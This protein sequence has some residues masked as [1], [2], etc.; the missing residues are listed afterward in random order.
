MNRFLLVT[1]RKSDRLW[2]LLFCFSLLAFCLRALIPN[3][4]MPTQS[5][6]SETSPLSL[7]FCLPAG[8]QSVA[9][10]QFLQSLQDDTS[11]STEQTGSIHTCPF[12]LASVDAILAVPI[13]LSDLRLPDVRF[14][15]PESQAP[16]VDTLHAGP[17]LGPRAPPLV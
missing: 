7:S 6:Q 5:T 15:L 14:V 10:E 11:H 16:P 1:A 13:E 4:Y 9:F 17:P 12:Q 2:Q 8:T 3:G